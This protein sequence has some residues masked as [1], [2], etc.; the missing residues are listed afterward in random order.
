MRVLW[1]SYQLVCLFYSCP[2]S[3]DPSFHRRRIVVGCYAHSLLLSLRVKCH[4]KAFERYLS[5]CPVLHTH[6]F[7]ISVAQWAYSCHR[8]LSESCWEHGTVLRLGARFLTLPH[9]CFLIILHRFLPHSMTCFLPR[10]SSIINAHLNPLCSKN[11]VPFLIVC[12]C[13]LESL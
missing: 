10:T 2:V 5:A 6:V 12:T 3:R 13:A 4:T 8:R 1:Q 9:E 11:H 7:I